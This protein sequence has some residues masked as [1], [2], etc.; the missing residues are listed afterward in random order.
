MK[1]GAG[2]SIG[3]IDGF[4]DQPSRPGGTSVAKIPRGR[5]WAILGPGDGIWRKAEPRQAATGVRTARLMIVASGR[6]PSLGLRADRE[7]LR[8][9]ELDPPQC[10]HGL[11]T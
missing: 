1:L 6:S 11:A 8:A 10:G 5:S 9:L 2:P 4:A 7:A 3:R